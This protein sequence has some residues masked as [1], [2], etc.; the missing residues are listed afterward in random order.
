MNDFLSGFKRGLAEGWRGYFAPLYPAP[1]RAA[2]HAAATPG[3]GLLAPFAA[4]LQEVE[5]II[6][7][8]K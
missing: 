4:W 5:I 6:G 2:W 1:W 7:G 3:A 8:R